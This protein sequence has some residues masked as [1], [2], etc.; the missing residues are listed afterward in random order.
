MSRCKWS[1]TMSCDICPDNLSCY[2]WLCDSCDGCRNNLIDG[3]CQLGVEDTC[4]NNGSFVYYDPKEPER[5]RDDGNQKN[6][7]YDIL[8]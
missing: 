3:R 7:R 5:R 8:D 6:S 2:T 4:R 1:S